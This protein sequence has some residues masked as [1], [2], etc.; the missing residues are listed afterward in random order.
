VAR[1]D[2]DL[3]QVTESLLSHNVKMHTFQRYFFG[4]STK[5]GLIFGYGAVDLLEL[6][7]GLTLLRKV[8]M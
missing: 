7:Q 1:A 8:L 6:R 3:E 2:L 5:T 4:P